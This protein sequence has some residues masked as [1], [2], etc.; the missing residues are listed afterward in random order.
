MAGKIKQI[1]KSPESRAEKRVAL[2]TSQDTHSNSPLAATAKD[3]GALREAVVDAAGVGTGLWLSYL[4]LFFYLFIAVAAVTHR[5][6]LFENPVKLPFLDVELSLY[7]FF[8]LGPLL[9]LVLQA[10]VLLHF[11]MLAA[12]VGVF[13]HEL[14]AQIS[15]DDTRTRL[16]RQL[17]SNIFVQYL[18]GPY[19]MRTGIMGFMLRLIAVISLSPLSDCAARLVPAQVPALS[20]RADYM[21]APHCRPDRYFSVVDALAIHCTWADD[22]DFMARLPP[23]ED[24]GAAV[25]EPC[26]ALASLYHRNLSRRMAG[27]TL[28]TL[29]LVP[30]K[31][32]TFKRPTLSLEN[33]QTDRVVDARN[34]K[35]NGTHAAD[36]EVAGKG[37]FWSTLPALVKSIQEESQTSGLRLPL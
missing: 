14:R 17:P 25:G 5:D 24:H 10:Y 2:S 1:G 31:W 16:R 36:Q 19:E 27:L 7:G 30:T 15:D 6:L 37:R 32:P 23:P 11:T 29:S 21:V 9:F 18:A 8:V 28:P 34:E 35:K 3:L 26:S 33:G 20:P 22:T 12:K 13:H 4:F